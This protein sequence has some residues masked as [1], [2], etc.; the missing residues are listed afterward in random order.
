[1]GHGVGPALCAHGRRVPQ[2]QET[3][4]LVTQCPEAPAPSAW[5]TCNVFSLAVHRGQ[6]RCMRASPLKTSLR[7]V[8]S[9]LVSPGGGCWVVAGTWAFGPWSHSP[10]LPLADVAGNRHRDQDARP[11]PQHG[12]H[13]ALL[14]TYRRRRRRRKTRTLQQLRLPGTKRFVPARVPVP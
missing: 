13:R 3:H 12:D 11:L 2:P 8:A 5:G 1:M 4:P 10:P 14:L 6:T 9:P 7:L